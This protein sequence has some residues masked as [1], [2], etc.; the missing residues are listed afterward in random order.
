MAINHH[1]K[2]TEMTDILQ[3]YYTSEDI[4]AAD[5]IDHY[6]G[7]CMV[8]PE[9]SIASIFGF[10][11]FVTALALMVLIYATTDVR[12]R[13][14]MATAPFPVRGVALFVMIFD[15]LGTLLTDMWFNEKWFLPVFLSNH[16]IIQGTFGGLFFGVVLVW[17]WYAFWSPPIFCRRNSR[18]FFETMS[19]FIE[20][21]DANELPIIAHEIS[22]SADAIIKHSAFIPAWRP[23]PA[24]TEKQKP[25]TAIYAYELLRL[26]ADRKF[27][28]NVVA[29]SPITAT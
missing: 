24:H 21:G 4:H 11:T 5:C 17:V 20:K 28:K 29:Y 12:Y 16:T 1:P 9:Q 19:Y 26:I 3:S 18:R 22:R 2:A 27:C 8:K 13:F 10:S 25:T 23:T 14:R 6:I 7:I 15:G